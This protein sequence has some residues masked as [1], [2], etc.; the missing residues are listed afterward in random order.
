ML[1]KEEKLKFHIQINKFSKL[2]RKMREIKF[3]F[4]HLFIPI[5]PPTRTLTPLSI[6]IRLLVLFSQYYFSLK[7]YENRDFDDRPSSFVSFFFVFSFT[8]EPSGDIHSPFH[9]YR[10]KSIY[11][12]GIHLY[13]EEKEEDLV[14]EKEMVQRNSL[15][16]QT[17]IAIHTL[18]LPPFF[19]LKKEYFLI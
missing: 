16:L 7:L 3:F 8:E 12:Y 13:K 18:H 9:I 1:Q 4:C 17:A 15:C 14:D 19:H 2:R 6:A 11:I 5:Q 10:Y